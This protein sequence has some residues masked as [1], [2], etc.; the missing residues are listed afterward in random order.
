MS[1]HRTLA[2]PSTISSM[3]IWTSLLSTP[4]TC[5]VWA[6][7]PMI[8]FDVGV[9]VPDRDRDG[10]VLRPV[11]LCIGDPVIYQNT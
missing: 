11:D 1:F 3:M 2:P 7:K 5:M 8:V 9:T 10:G 4:F 6:F